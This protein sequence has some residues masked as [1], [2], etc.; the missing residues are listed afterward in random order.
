MLRN[1]YDKGLKAISFIKFYA[2]EYAVLKAVKLS[3]T[4][5]L[6]FK[7]GSKNR[8]QNTFFIFNKMG[9]FSLPNEMRIVIKIVHGAI[10]QTE[11]C[12]D[13]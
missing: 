6:R 8:L 12:A 1:L 13:D 10:P 11:K 2:L 7:V 3:S 9:F 4:R 5:P